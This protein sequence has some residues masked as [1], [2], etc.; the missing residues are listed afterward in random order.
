M[1]K[2]NN[3]KKK[4]QGQSESDQLHVTWT[5]IPVSSCS[6]IL[7][8]KHA[9][10]Y[11][12]AAPFTRVSLISPSVLTGTPISL[13]KKPTGLCELR[14]SRFFAFF[15]FSCKISFHA[16]VTVRAAVPWML[17]MRTDAMVGKKKKMLCVS[18]LIHRTSINTGT[19]GRVSRCCSRMFMSEP[20]LLADCRYETESLQLP[21]SS[22]A[23]A[24]PALQTHECLMMPSRGGGLTLAP[25]Q[26]PQAAAI[27]SGCGLGHG[28]KTGKDQ[29]ELQRG[30]GRWKCSLVIPLHM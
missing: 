23:S 22:S 7:K 30:E 17:H 5:I 20:C 11:C 25:N 9:L 16:R 18:S 21:G 3:R 6:L 10:Q 2:K 27:L 29:K 19:R 26:S 1:E 14:H 15:F 8:E 24:P 28:W 4:Y 13:Q 12:A